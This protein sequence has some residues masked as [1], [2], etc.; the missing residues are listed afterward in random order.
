MRLGNTKLICINLLA[1][2]SLSFYYQSEVGELL[3]YVFQVAGY[4]LVE[5]E[6][7]L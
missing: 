2:L 6:K 3:E 5:L 4:N 7:V 1:L